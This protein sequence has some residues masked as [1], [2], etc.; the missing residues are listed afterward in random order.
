MASVRRSLIGAQ[1][2]RAA[3]LRGHSVEGHQHLPLLAAIDDAE[4][5]FQPRWS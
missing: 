1:A 4:L 3:I 2:G 5:P